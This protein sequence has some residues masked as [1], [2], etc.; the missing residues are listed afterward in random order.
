[1]GGARYARHLEADINH[2]GVS[3]EVELQDD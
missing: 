3:Y 1:V 2:R